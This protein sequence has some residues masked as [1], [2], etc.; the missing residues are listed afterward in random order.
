MTRNQIIQ[1]MQSN[2]QRRGKMWRLF[3]E[4]QIALAKAAHPETGG[5]LGMV[6]NWGNEAARSVVERGDARWSKI[7]AAYEKR[8]DALIN[9]LRHA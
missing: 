1:A 8:Y 6:H 3:C 9:A 4:R 5:H 2:A 7:D